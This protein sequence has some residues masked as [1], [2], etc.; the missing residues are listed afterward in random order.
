MNLLPPSE[1]Q[2]RGISLRRAP[3]A[4][5]AAV[6]LGL[7]S[8][9]VAFWGTTGTGAAP[10]SVGNVQAITASPGVATTQIY[11]GGSADVALTLS[12]PN[13]VG[14]HVA[15]LSLDTTHGTAG[16]G[17]DAGHAACDLAALALTSQTNAGAGWSVPRRVG[18]TNGSRAIDLAGSLAMSTGAATA[19]QGASFTV[20]LSAG[21]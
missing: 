19:C 11:P 15:S 6:S 13:V 1:A 3:G 17:V 2:R 20:Y 14:V 4:I 5:A 10:A 9:A 16:F 21:P 8:I 18:S 12:N 7:A